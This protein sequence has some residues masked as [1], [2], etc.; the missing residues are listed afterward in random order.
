M[1]PLPSNA[2]TEKSGAAPVP[3]PSRAIAVVATAAGFHKGHRKSEGD[4]FTVAKFEELGS[5]MKCVD[6]TM[7][8]KH[9]EHQRSLK[10]KR[11]GASKAP[12]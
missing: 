2:A 8:K 12:A 3:Q 5:W 7:Q 6:P 9:E 11:A 4:A 1:P 10:E